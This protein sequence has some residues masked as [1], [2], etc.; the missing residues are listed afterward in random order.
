MTP[1][2]RSWGHQDLQDSPR[3]AVQRKGKEARQPTG[4][5]YTI[6]LHISYP[7]EDRENRAQG[8]LRGLSGNDIMIHEHQEMSSQPTRLTGQGYNPG[9]LRD[10]GDPKMCR[11]ILIKCHN[12]Q[13]CPVTRSITC[14]YDHEKE[15]P[16]SKAIEARLHQEASTCRHVRS[17]AVCSKLCTS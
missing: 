3:V 1:A 11:N 15:K 9:S 14:L 5:I 12:C 8:K 2:R 10:R 17:H 6:S 4:K 13:Y 16:H 7:N